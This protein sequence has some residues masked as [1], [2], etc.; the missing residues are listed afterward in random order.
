MWPAV[1]RRGE[2]EE[3]HSFA[4]G[5]IAAVEQW[6][7]YWRQVVTNRAGHADLLGFQALRGCGS[8]PTNWI[9][10]LAQAA[11]AK[12]TGALHKR[13]LVWCQRTGGN[14]DEQWGVFDALGL[15]QQIGGVPT[16]R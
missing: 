16:P 15:M 4:Y 14:I 7:E 8:Q 13:Y 11:T 10:K 3:S 5:L 6:A 12:K 1:V 2:E 9:N